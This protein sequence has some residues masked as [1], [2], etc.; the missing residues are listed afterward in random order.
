MPASEEGFHPVQIGQYWQ[1]K[2]PLGWPLCPRHSLGSGLLFFAPLNEGAGTSVYDATGGAG[3]AV[4][5]AAALTVTGGAAWAPGGYRFGTGLDLTAT[6]S[7][8][9]AVI[10]S[11]L[12]LNKPL[13]LAV[14][15]RWNGTGP[16]THSPLFGL[17]VS[18]ASSGNAAYRIQMSGGSGALELGGAS[19][20]TLTGTTLVSGVNSVAV[21]TI[22]PS[23]N[24]LAYLNGVQTT[25]TTGPANPSYTATAQVAFGSPSGFTSTSIS[26]CRVFWGAIWNRVLSAQEAQALWESP[27]RLF[28]P[29]EPH[30]ESIPP[31]P[32]GVTWPQGT[33]RPVTRRIPFRRGHAG[34]TSQYPPSP[35]PPG[36]TWPQGTARPVTRRIPFR[37]GRSTI[38][39]YA[40]P[41]IP[42]GHVRIQGNWSD[43]TNSVNFPV[44]RTK[45]SASWFWRS[46]AV[47]PAVG[48]T[49]ISTTNLSFNMAGSLT[50]ATLRTNHDPSLGVTDIISSFN[51]Q[52]G[53]IYHIAL[54]YDGTGPTKVQQWYLNGQPLAG[55]HTGSNQAAA[56]SN[57]IQI[58][59][60]SNTA[61]TDFSI[62][63]LAVWDGYALTPTEIANLCARAIDPT[64]TATPA[65]AWYPLAGPSVPSTPP[66]H[67][68][69][70]TK[71][72][73]SGSGTL[74][75]GTP[76]VASTASVAS[77]QVV[78]G[79]SGYVS[80]TASFSGGGGTGAAGTVLTLGG[81]VVGVTFTAAGSG[82]TSAPTVTISDTGGGSGATATAALV[83]R[84]SYLP[85]VLRV[86]PAVVLADAYID[87]S[88]LL[89]F[90][91]VAA[92]YFGF[93]I[94]TNGGEYSKGLLSARVTAPGS[95]YVNPVATV[96]PGQV[97][98]GFVN[99][100]TI[101]APGSG[102][103]TTTPAVTIAPPPSGRTATASATAS[104]V[105]VGV[106]VANGG[107]G[108]P[109]NTTLTCSG[110]GLTP[111]LTNGVITGA[112]ISNPGTGLS[113]P[114]VTITDPTGSGAL[115]IVAPTQVTSGHITGFTQVSGG[116]NYSASPTVTIAPTPGSPGSG[117]TATATVVGGVITALNLTAGGSSYGTPPVVTAHTNTGTATPTIAIYPIL[118]GGITALSIG[119]AGSGYASAPGITL[120][121]PSAPGG[122]AATVTSSVLTYIPAV[123]GPPLVSGGQIVGIPVA[124]AGQ[125]H[126]GT[127]TIVITDTG[128]GTG[129]VATP[130]MGGLLI[131]ITQA[132]VA[133]AAGDTPS[134]DGL[135]TL[136]L[137]GHALAPGLSVTGY[138]V[139]AA[140]SGYTS[141]PTVTITPAAGDDTG[142]GATATATASGGA[143]TAVS[144]VQTGTT[145][146]SSGGG[147]TLGPTVGFS[148]GGGTGA[149][150]TAVLSPMWAMGAAVGPVTNAIDE[151]WCA[152][153]IGCNSVASIVPAGGG[154][155]YTHATVTIDAPTGPGGVRATATATISGGAITGFT[156]TNAGSGYLV[157]PG[158]AISGDG[159][160]AAAGAVMTGVQATDT[161]TYSLPGTW[162]TTAIGSPAAATGTFSN[163]VGFTEPNLIIPAASRTM[164]LGFNVCSVPG[165][166]SEPMALGQ[167]WVRRIPSPWNG[168]G[169]I[170]S[171]TIGSIGSGYSSSPTVTIGAA[172][173][174]GVTATATAIVVG[175]CVMGLNLTNPGR[176]YTTAPSVTITDVAGSGASYTATLNPI[177]TSTGGLRTFAPGT[178]ATG[179]MSFTGGTPNACGASILFSGGGGSGAAAIASTSSGVITSLTL[180]APAV[181]MVQ[182]TARGSGYSPGAAVTFGAPT[183]SSGTTAT[184]T[185]SI[186]AGTVVSA[187][188]TAAGSGYTT[189]PTVTFG[190]APGG[191]VTA[192]GIAYTDGSGVTSVYVTNGGTG[193]LSAPSISFGGPGTGA[194][195]TCTIES[196]TVVGITV[197]NPGW[198]YTL[199][200]PPTCSVAG[201]TGA[202]FTPFMC[203]APASRCGSGY[204][205]PPTI[206]ITSGSGWNATATCTIDG[207]GH[208]NGTTVTN[209]GGGYADGFF[210]LAYDDANPACPTFAAVLPFGA[211]TVG[212]NPLITFLPARSA[213]GTIVGTTRTNIIR[214]Y[215]A[216]LTPSAVASAQQDIEV[217]VG[218][219]QAT[220]ANGALDTLWVAAPD[221]PLNRS[222][223]VAPDATSVGLLTTASDKG[224]GSCR[225]VVAALGGG[226]QSSAVDVD[227]LVNPTDS[228]ASQNLQQDSPWMAADGPRRVRITAFRPYDPVTPSHPGGGSSGNV[229][230]H[231][232]YP[233]TVTS[234]NLSLA[235]YMFVV[236]DGTGPSWLNWGLG[237]TIWAIGECVTSAPHNLKTG[238]LFTL[239]SGA[240]L[241]PRVQVTAGFTAGVPNNYFSAQ[242]GAALGAFFGVAYVTGPTTFCFTFGGSTG[243]TSPSEPLGISNIAFTQQQGSLF[244]ITGGTGGSG[245]TQGTVG[246]SF[247]GG[248]GSGAAA[249][250]IVASGA[251]S[252]VLITSGGTGYTSAP[253]VTI[254]DSG[255]GSGATG[256]TAALTTHYPCDLSLVQTKAT[257]PYEA[258]AA[259][260]AAAGADLWVNVP[261]AATDAMVASIAQRCRDNTK[262]GGRVHVETSN[263]VFNIGFRQVQFYAALGWLSPNPVI[264]YR[265]HTHRSAQNWATFVSVFNQADINGNTNRGVEIVRVM[266][267][268][269]GATSQTSAI[270]QQLAAD[271]AGFDELAFAP[272]WDVTQDPPF[273]WACAA[274]APGQATSKAFGATW[275]WTMDM[276]QTLIRHMVRYNQNINGTGRGG[277]SQ[278]SAA[279]QLAVLANYQA[280]TGQTNTPTIVT[281]EAAP[282]ALI[283]PVDTSGSNVVNT[284][285]SHD[286]MYHPRIYDLHSAYLSSL[287]S[288]GLTLHNHF[289]LEQPRR[290]TVANTYDVWGLIT[291]C[292]TRPALGDGSD[293]KGVNKFWNTAAG[294][295]GSLH[296]LTNVSPGLQAAHDWIDATSP[297]PPAQP[298]LPLIM[299]PTARRGGAGPLAGFVRGRGGIARPGGAGATGGGSPPPTSTRTAKRWYPGL[300]PRARLSR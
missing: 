41:S 173:A 49:V 101:V 141:A 135:P 245:Y 66:A 78:A 178:I 287:Q 92:S 172:P 228:W 225:F 39:S 4:S 204:A 100:L 54:S 286:A 117:A 261:P 181:Q 29:P 159:S 55:S 87:R 148:G 114:V 63:D 230:V 142:S 71:N 192:T 206:Q 56:G 115:F 190:A 105:C 295:D 94:N 158:V 163:Y 266:T 252:Y 271:G 232:N 153:P 199:A 184:G 216:Q 277:Q 275:P 260:C 136:S 30:F 58:G 264:G 276:W 89:A 14:A 157:V 106:Y 194:T 198:G 75:F 38:G 20:T 196:G 223:P 112:T 64:Q 107:S 37:R 125:G 246:V 34:Q 28:A 44:S 238:Q 176:G 111:I 110:I 86:T 224:A 257:A 45:F 193:Y 207:T 291:W 274:M 243:A 99:G 272:Y 211:S 129:A 269:P 270:L 239:G 70:G 156:V 8:A 160:G 13:T 278:G 60:S 154:S 231:Q 218:V 293:G 138:Q 169:S 265:A 253:T 59:T 255:S 76:A 249:T 212:A 250:A 137:N 248:G 130:V 165:D 11:A 179:T 197:T 21:V 241:A 234:D 186:S 35:P 147:Y 72:K 292:G 97:T 220:G 298:M 240:T 1:A 102:Y 32:P 12:K 2:P 95:G 83:Y 81:Q 202:T 226:G 149:A 237:N 84:T 88:G 182:V 229:Y 127:P 294:G 18:N 42:T 22:D 33:A 16:A 118:S 85:E 27:W 244:S 152:F 164:R 171:F 7:G 62:S 43:S 91:H 162:P 297:A 48:V 284:G 188:V 273:V 9:N 104:G 61:A 128:G 31:P 279:A 120:A 242:A 146:N 53:Q 263:E 145:P 74:D 267:V 256:W 191:G 26:Q 73:M 57:I 79:G 6:S 254:T 17:S 80:P 19:L 69:F 96:V 259:C 222:N 168:S 109:V 144:L 155:G 213:G 235:P 116:S 221:N 151:P 262:P 283:P 215:H 47:F 126:I 36:V 98:A 90:F 236:P 51:W 281:Y 65:S 161:V 133:V 68:D 123:L 290:L 282:E 185:A 67:G 121:P 203:Y 288:I 167:N 143:V 195:A 201:G 24:V 150:A 183:D 251:V 209:G 15:C 132:G 227:D 205:S 208:V 210:T 280:I 300:S 180:V 124:N 219:T 140:G 268:A 93:Q 170:G 247:S 299:R 175:Q 46:N 10:A 214:G 82:Y 187:T 217:I 258:M 200:S 52:P 103:T 108:F 285:L 77:V 50:S 40:L 177:T 166:R 134:A 174:G 5:P 296:D 3:L 131:P 25:S 139:T 233:G 23:G 189:A 122:V 119:D 113:G 289:Q